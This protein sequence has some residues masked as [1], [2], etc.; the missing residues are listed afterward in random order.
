M[1]VPV[2]YMIIFRD[3]LTKSAHNAIIY[4]YVYL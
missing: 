1:P 2:S 4:G 3:L